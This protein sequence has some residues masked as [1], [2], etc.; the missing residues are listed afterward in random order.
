VLIHGDSFIRIIT[1]AAFNSM[2]HRL[3]SLPL[4][5]VAFQAE[6]S[7]ISRLAAN[8]NLQVDIRRIIRRK[9]LRKAMDSISP[10]ST[11]HFSERKK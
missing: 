2:I 6:C 7:V 1:N 4:S 9:L 3:L 8:N 10:L 5:P 11:L